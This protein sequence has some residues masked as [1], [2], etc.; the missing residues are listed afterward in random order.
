MSKSLF[1]AAWKQELGGSTD[2]RRVTA[3]DYAGAGEQWQPG[4]SDGAMAAEGSPW[5]RF[6]QPGHYLS[7]NCTTEK[8]KQRMWLQDTVDIFEKS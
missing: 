8:S 3:S 1:R 5:P 6:R 7:F 2:P 4:C